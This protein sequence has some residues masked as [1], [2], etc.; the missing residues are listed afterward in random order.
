MANRLRFKE[1][2]MRRR[3][4]WNRRNRE[5]TSDWNALIAKERS[6]KSCSRPGSGFHHCRSLRND[7]HVAIDPRQAGR[8]ELKQVIG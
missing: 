7:G 5:E 4:E 1:E 6:G 2:L 8:P 3:P